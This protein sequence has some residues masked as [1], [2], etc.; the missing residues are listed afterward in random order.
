M[1]SWS[2]QCDTLGTVDWNTSRPELHPTVLRNTD[3]SADAYERFAGYFSYTGRS[4]D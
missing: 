1:R 3:Q 2:P 4:S